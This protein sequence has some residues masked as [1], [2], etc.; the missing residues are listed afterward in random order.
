MSSKFGM[1]VEF[2]LP[3]QVPSL[4][5]KLQVD[6]R[7]YGH[8]FEKSTWCH[9]STADH[10]IMTT[11]SRLMQNDMPITTHKS[12]LK[13]KIRFQYGIHLYSETGSSNISV[14]D[15]YGTECT[16]TI[17]KIHETLFIWS[18]LCVMQIFD[19]TETVL[20]GKNFPRGCREFPEFSLSCPCLWKSLSSPGFPGLWSPCFIINKWTDK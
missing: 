9:N 18:P 4:K 8:H 3:K 19:R 14:M 2:H 6:L 11:L 7:L 1:Q 20:S 10:L 17:S 15:W 12:K 16:V 5:L 13:P